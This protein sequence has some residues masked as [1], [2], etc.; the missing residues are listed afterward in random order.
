MNKLHPSRSHLLKIQ[1][2]NSTQD[3][4]ES[5]SNH[6][7]FLNHNHLRNSQRSVS[8]ISSINIAW[9]ASRKRPPMLLYG[10]VLLYVLIAPSSTWSLMV[11]LEFMQRTFSMSIGMTTSLDLF[12][13]VQIKSCLIFRRNTIFRN[14]HLSKDT[15]MLLS[16]GTPKCIRQEWTEFLINSK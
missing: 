7:Q 6:H 1:H 14:Y 9:I 5:F 12:K 15:L 13:W 16:F 8:Q 10:Q 4:M 11:N 2:M 3:L